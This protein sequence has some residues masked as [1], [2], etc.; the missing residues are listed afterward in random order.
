[1]NVNK[2]NFAV[3]SRIIESSFV[4]GPGHRM[5]IF[6]QGCNLN[7]IYCHNPET[8]GICKQ[9]FSCIDNC[10]HKALTL[11]KNN[12]IFNHKLCQKCDLCIKNCPHSSNPHSYKISIDTL[13]KKVNEEQNFIDGVTFSGGEATKWSQFIIN[14]ITT[15]KK[16]PHSPCSPSSNSATNLT[17]FIDTNGYNNIQ[18]FNKLSSVID[19][20]M[21]DLKAI[22]PTIHANITGKKNQNI[23]ENFKLISDK[24]LLFEIR[25]VFIEGINDSE[26]EV[27]NIL[28]FVKNLND[29]TN[30]KIIPFRPQGVIGYL[31]DS[32]PYP[33]EKLNIIKEKACKM[34]GVKR[35]ILSESESESNSNSNSNSE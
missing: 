18:T 32:T 30:F 25:T 29:Y 8:I 7:C 34:L 15:I 12:I 24:K 9:C 27:L 1:M 31:K 10:K 13:I 6:F 14:L 23:L 21:F 4:D 2:K 3:V 19:G 20:F 16:L 22:N 35:V 17:F 5:V 11:S 33:R 26:Q 28:N